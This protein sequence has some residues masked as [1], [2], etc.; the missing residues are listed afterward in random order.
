MEGVYYF[1]KNESLAQ[2]NGRFTEQDII[3]ALS[4][5]GYSKTMR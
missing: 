2:K 5:A 1:L 4:R 3:E